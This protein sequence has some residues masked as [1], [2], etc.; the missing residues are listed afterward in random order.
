MDPN[1]MFDQILEEFADGAYTDQV[2]HA[3]QEFFEQVSDVRED[4]PSYEKLTSC[5]LNWY[6]YDRPMDGGPNTPLQIFA[7]RAG[8]DQAQ[9]EECARLAANLHS[10]FA[11]LRIEEHGLLLIDLFSL[12]ELQVSER[13]HLAGLEKG[14]LLEARL[15]PLS[16]RL[17]FSPA[18]T[19]LHARAAQALIRASVERS[20]RDALPSRE[21]LL[22]RLRALTFRFT[23]RYRERVPVEK[24]FG[25]LE[26]FTGLEPQ[27]EAEQVSASED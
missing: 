9:R 12:E 17:V 25:D 23:D 20:R 19:I 3:R 6:I 27:V 1:S 5:F 8:R 22:A 24:V 15:M 2:R 16:D 18:A 21:K 10:L 14:D 11:I 4:D 26:F 7:S 13:R